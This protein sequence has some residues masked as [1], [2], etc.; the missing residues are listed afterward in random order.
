MPATSWGRVTPHRAAHE[1]WVRDRNDDLPQAACAHG[2]MLPH[3]LGRSYGDVALNDGGHLLRTRALDRFISFDAG[4]GVLRAESGVSLEDVIDLVLPQGW[5]LAVTPGTRFV[6]LGGAVA[7]DVHG[8]NHHGAGSFGHHVRAIELL[9]SD[10]TRLECSEGRNA[11]WLDAT[12]GGLGLTGLIT[13]VEIQLVRVRSPMLWAVHRRFA[14]LDHYWA[15]D[16]ALGKRHEFTVAWVD[17]LHGAR[18]IFTAAD[19]A[20]AGT[21]ADAPPRPARRMPAD[22]PFSLVN[23]VTLRAFNALY[24]HR[25]LRAQRLVH[26]LP[27]F[28]P[29][30]GILHWNRMYGRRGFYQYQ[31][32][33]PAGAMRPAAKEM[34]RLIERRGEG[35][36]LAVFKTFGERP[37]RGLLSFARSGVTLAMDFPNRGQTTQTIFAE[38]DAVVREAGGA[39]Y[40]AKDARMPAAMFASGYPQVDR[41][42][43][44]VDPRFS[45]SFWRRVMA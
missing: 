24:F 34:F 9:R 11:D 30:D 35:S 5:F 20:G 25:P 7:N 42:V 41:F 16:D 40:P 22:P 31:C 14:T 17:C 36:F 29:L 38:L 45:S 13:W 23:G 28:F 12:I 10:G 21:K 4:S 39:L 6:T 3:G 26:C 15:L 43:R 27:F 1:W 18:G 33:L 8:K 44:F 32:V 2:S 19:F 37:G